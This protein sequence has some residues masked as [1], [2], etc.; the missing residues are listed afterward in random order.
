VPSRKRL[1]SPTHLL[2]ESS[3]VPLLLDKQTNNA[4]KRGEEREEEERARQTTPTSP[5]HFLN[6]NGL[7][8]SLAVRI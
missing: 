5:P 3:G 7:S 4:S 6:P 2:L 1:F 8:L